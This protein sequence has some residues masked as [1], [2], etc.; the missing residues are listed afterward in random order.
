MSQTLKALKLIMHMHAYRVKVQRRKATHMSSRIASHVCLLVRH[1]QTANI[2]RAHEVRTLSGSATGR[3][4]PKK[5]GISFETAVN[6]P[7]VGRAVGRVIV[8]VTWRASLHAL[9]VNGHCPPRQRAPA[10]S[11]RPFSVFQSTTAFCSLPFIATQTMDLCSVGCRRRSQSRPTRF[12]RSLRP[13]TR[14]RTCISRASY[15]ALR[16]ANKRSTRS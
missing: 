9:T 2:D 1:A 10:A 11:R 4:R 15:S 14:L 8:R 7:K 3:V 13:P 5:P 6:G 12:V 16:A